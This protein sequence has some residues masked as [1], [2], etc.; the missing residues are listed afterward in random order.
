MNQH[1]EKI[2]VFGGYGLVGS[3]IVKQAVAR[4][5]SV[6][7]IGSD[8][9]KL[10]AMSQAADGDIETLAHR[11]KLDK[12]K[13]LGIDGPLGAIVTP[14]G[15]ALSMRK[16]SQISG[17]TMQE[18]MSTKLAL[19]V[20]AVRLGLPLLAPEGAIVLFS[21]ILSRQPVPELAEMSAINAAVEAYARALAVELAPI[22]VNCIS[23]GMMTED[24]GEDSVSVDDVARVVLGVLDM[25]LSGAVLDILPTGR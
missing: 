10:S 14:L 3:A 21:G 5:R 11:I 24:G 19:Q 13:G 1:N 8:E 2:A 16:A 15:G 20:E 4:G 12:G 23:P 9:N 7:A 17:A 18:A 22:R 25:P 6:L